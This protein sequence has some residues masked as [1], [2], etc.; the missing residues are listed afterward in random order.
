MFHARGLRT[1]GS[2]NII[3]R[4]RYDNYIAQL[5][6]IPNS[7][8]LKYKMESGSINVMLHFI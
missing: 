6:I 2:V 1:S 7:N 3:L 4:V 8:I 5:T